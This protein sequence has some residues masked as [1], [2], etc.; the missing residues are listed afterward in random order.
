MGRKK[1]SETLQ[2]GIDLG[3]N[4]ITGLAFYYGG[5]PLVV[6]S[7][8]AISKS[9]PERSLVAAFDEFAG[10]HME[11]SSGRKPWPDVVAPDFVALMGRLGIVVDQAT[12]LQAWRRNHG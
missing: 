6:F 1:P 12:L 2:V 8:E 7:L 5:K 10:F 3:T 11:A 4:E 9:K